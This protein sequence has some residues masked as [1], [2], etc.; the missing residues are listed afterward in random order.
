MIGDDGGGLTLVAM[1]VVAVALT[2]LG[3]AAFR[4]RDLTA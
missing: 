1:A 2:A 4:R 3:A